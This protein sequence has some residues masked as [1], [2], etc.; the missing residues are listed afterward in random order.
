ML[1]PRFGAFL[2]GFHDDKDRADV[3]GVGG[4]KQRVPADGNPVRDSR[5]VF[6]NLVDAVAE[7]PAVRSSE[8]ASGSWMLTM[9]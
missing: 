8:A 3:G 9:T 4:V 6:E 1:R 7:P 2:P 5:G